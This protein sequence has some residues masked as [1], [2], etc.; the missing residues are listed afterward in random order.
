MRGEFSFSRG[1]EGVS[2]TLGETRQ[3]LIR[4]RYYTVCAEPI[5]LCRRKKA[6]DRSQHSAGLFL[7][8]TSI[9]P[10][11]QQINRSNVWMEHRLL[12]LRSSPRPIIHGSEERSPVRYLK[13]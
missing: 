7:H 6:L 1:F 9:R 12:P 3:Q 8:I 10:R 4:R 11:P 2:R 13:N 5:I